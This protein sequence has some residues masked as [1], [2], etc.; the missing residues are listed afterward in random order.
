MAFLIFALELD[1]WGLR[2]QHNHSGHLYKQMNRLGMSVAGCV[3]IPKF[4]LNH[5][6]GWGADPTVV[7]LAHFGCA[8]VE[9]HE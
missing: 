8:A 3:G 6:E 5:V 4:S 7:V 1:P 2:N 9:Q